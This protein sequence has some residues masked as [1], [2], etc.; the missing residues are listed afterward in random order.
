MNGT[1]IDTTILGQSGSGFNDNKEGDI[2]LSQ[3]PEMESQS[4][5]L[6]LLGKAWISLF[7][8]SYW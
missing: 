2:I 5:L 4:C 7:S 1:L 8:P 6:M 3:T